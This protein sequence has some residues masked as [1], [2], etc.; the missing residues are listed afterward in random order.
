DIPWSP[1]HPSRAFLEETDALFEPALSDKPFLLAWGLRDFV[2]TP[3]FL[4]DFK[5]RLRRARTLALPR[6]GHYLLEDEPD[7]ILKALKRFWTG[8]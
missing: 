5:R 8:S 3:I 7:K 1:G 2:F 6:S 4:H